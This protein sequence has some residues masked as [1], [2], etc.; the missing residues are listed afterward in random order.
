VN[1]SHNQMDHH[2]MGAGGVG[3]ADTAGI[4]SLT[5]VEGS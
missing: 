2:H 1:V 5:T 4:L 3:Y